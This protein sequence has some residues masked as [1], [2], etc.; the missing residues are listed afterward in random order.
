M[1]QCFVKASLCRKNDIDYCDDEDD[2]T[3][4]DVDL[5]SG[6]VHL[7]TTT[8]S[9]EEKISESIKDHKIVL[10]NFSTNWCSPCRKIAPLYS[11]IADK[12]PSFICL[13]VDVD[14]LPEFSTKWAIRATPTFYFLK[15]GQQVDKLI[16]GNKEELQKKIAAISSLLNG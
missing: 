9:W 7:I 14:E 5:A 6:N 16:G 13:T 8:A 15:D 11:E 2:D 10:A 3:Y 4:H 1:G 12:H